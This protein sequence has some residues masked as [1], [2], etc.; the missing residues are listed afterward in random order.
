MR[1]AD[2]GWAAC[3]GL[4][5]RRAVTVEAALIGDYATFEDYG[6]VLVWSLAGWRGTYGTG[7]CARPRRRV[8]LEVVAVVADGA[9]LMLMRPRRRGRRCQVTGPVAVVLALRRAALLAGCW[10]DKYAKQ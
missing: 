5:V 6:L 4:R 1:T 2:A 9:R 7:G 10:R 3:A 8:H